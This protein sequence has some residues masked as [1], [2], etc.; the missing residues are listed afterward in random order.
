[1][2]TFHAAEE[3]SEQEKQPH[4]KTDP[5][6]NPNVKEED[7]KPDVFKT[8]VHV[9]PDEHLKALKP[10]VDTT[11]GVAGALQIMQHT[12]TPQTMESYQL[13]GRPSEKKGESLR[14]MREAAEIDPG[15]FNG[16]KFNFSLNQYDEFGRLMTPKEAF[17]QMC[18]RFHG[19]PPGKARKEKRLREVKEEKDLKGMA[20]GDTPTG[21]MNR[22]FEVQRQQASPYVVLSGKVNP[23]QASDAATGYSYA[24]KEENTALHNTGSIASALMSESQW[25]SEPQATQDAANAFN[26]SAGQNR[27]VE[28]NLGSKRK[29]SAAAS[30]HGSKRA[31]TKAVEPHYDDNDNDE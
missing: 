17:R 9:E 6:E 14:V 19:M 15:G 27:K 31:R 26:Q 5:E 16:R 22:V 8:D 18:W 28:F 24:E 11:R 4:I 30:G 29:A 25:S 1:M 21:S 23:G 12:N 7:E 2:P 20:Q 3:D 13:A 10:E